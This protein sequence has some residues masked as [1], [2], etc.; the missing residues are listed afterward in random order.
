[1]EAAPEA[2]PPKPKIAAT[3]AITKNITVQRNINKVLLLTNFFYLVIKELYQKLLSVAF[4]FATS[5]NY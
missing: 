3:I 5:V 2:I 4:I 1:M